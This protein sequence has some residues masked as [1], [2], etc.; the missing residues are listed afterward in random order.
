MIYY[1]KKLILFPILG[2]YFQLQV[3]QFFIYD[4]WWN[5]KIEKLNHQLNFCLMYWMISGVFY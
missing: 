1:K 3:P 2:Q 5:M 4:S